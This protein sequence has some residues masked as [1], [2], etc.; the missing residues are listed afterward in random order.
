L[1][2]LVESKGAIPF[3]VQIAVLHQDEAG[4]KFIHIKT[5]NQRVKTPMNFI[6]KS[7]LKLL[8]HNAQHPA[9]IVDKSKNYVY[10]F[11]LS[12]SDTSFGEIPTIEFTA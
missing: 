11:F 5:D 12:E 4:A 3:E 8:E 1:S 9:K 7:V 2:K 10:N 6:D